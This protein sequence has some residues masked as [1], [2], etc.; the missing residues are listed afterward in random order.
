MRTIVNRMAVAAV[1]ERNGAG[2][3]LPRLAALL[4]IALSLVLSGC[5]SG[6]PRVA[7]E[8]K[9]VEEWGRCLHPQPAANILCLQL[10]RP[11]M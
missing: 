3:G 6:L 2:A 10:R 11:P 1:E 7:E 8:T 9:V 4:V 5:V